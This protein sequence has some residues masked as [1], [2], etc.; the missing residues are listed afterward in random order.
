MTTRSR[1]A[2][3]GVATVSLVVFASWLGF[4]WGGP[5]ASTIVTNSGEIASSVF[6]MTCAAI[7]ARNARGSQRVGWICLTVGAAG[8]VAGNLYLAG[9]EAVPH[10]A[11][12]A[13]TIA[14]FGFLAL[15]VGAWLAALFVPTHR[16]GRFGLRILLDGVIAATSLFMIAWA[17]VL[18]HVLDVG[19]VSGPSLALA[20]AYP[21]ADIA[22]VTMGLLLL[23]KAPKGF[24]LMPLLVTASITVIAVS[25]GFSIFVTAGALE[26]TY[27]IVVGWTTGM[28]LLGV[29]AL[30]SKYAPPTHFESPG[31]PL[32]RSLWLPYLPVPFAFAI[33]THE[34]WPDRETAPLL[35]V[36]AMLVL[37][38]L[39]RQFLLLDEN[40]RLLVAVADVALR[41]PLTGLANRALFTDRLAHAMQLRDRTGAPVGILLADLDDFKLVNDSMGHPVGDDLLRNVGERIQNSIRPGDTVARLGG[42]EF[43]ILVE[44]APAIAEQIAER[45]VRAFD[46][47][48]QMAGRTVYM[49]LSIGLATAVG[50][51]DVSGDELFKRADLAMYSAKRAHV[52]ARTFTPD[53]R[54][55][56]TELNLPSQQQK[57]GRRGGVAR[58]QFLGD[59]RRAIDERELDLVYQPKFSLATGSVVGVESLI[60]WP[61]PEF[62]L[63]EPADFLPLVREN[64]LM[65]AVTDLVLERAV[66]DAAGWFDA[67][68]NLPVA[69]NLSAPS[70]NDE[71]L[72]ARVLSV[73]AAH[74]MPPTSLTV[75]IT[76]DLLLASVVRARTILDR[77]RESGIRVA[78]DDFG[79]GY[80]A[81]TYLH[82][83]PVDELKLDRQFIAPILHDER[84][85]AIVRSVVEL[86]I[87]FGLTSVAEGVEDKATAEL[88]KSY[89]CGFGQGHYFSP[90]VPAQAI[91]L[92]IGLATPDD[93]PLMPTEATRPSWA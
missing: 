55:D 85:A 17:L 63:L 39:I 6:A 21:V 72:P 38:T 5:T 25:D 54:R 62:G 83:L 32:Q 51:A 10:H 40:R 90:P 57:T 37:A 36:G 18:R 81:M 22:M 66:E 65:E 12:R 20:F 78:I 79:S 67:G 59:L 84:A 64:G 71:T 47:P 74:G 58:I 19:D 77:L 11:P 46:E 73:L 53:M 69:I 61:H 86:A 4:G 50:N 16:G 27:L 23:S 75:E 87:E 8:W 60:R 29:A 28:Y 3:I 2:T 49:Q 68:I 48:F 56:A 44:D 24:R 30:H 31:P 45:V 70:L 13:G 88:L 42:D 43:A 33:G 9:F 34:L 76:E 92:G 91:R 89:G 80:A 82:E 41:D 52:G 14:D 15:P 26:P 35:A 93:G 1:R 7:A